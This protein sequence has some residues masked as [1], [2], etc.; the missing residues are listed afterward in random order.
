MR[1][2][3]GEGLALDFVP[4]E[5]MRR[6]GKVRAL[7]AVRAHLF[8]GVDLEV[9]KKAANESVGNSVEYL[10]AVRRF[11]YLGSKY[12]F[13]GLFGNKSYKVY[14]V[15][16]KTEID[17]SVHIEFDVEISRV[18]FHGAEEELKTAIL[19]RSAYRSVFRGSYILF[20]SGEM[21][22]KFLI[23]I[24]YLSLCANVVGCGEIGSIDVYCGDFRP[25]RSAVGF[26]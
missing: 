11:V 10:P 12:F 23:V 21:H 14:N 18:I 17:A 1:L 5:V 8:A 2:V 25:I 24:A 15:A 13:G 16:S 19:A 3:E 22:E 7:I 6:L 4:R 26:F 9:R 20:N